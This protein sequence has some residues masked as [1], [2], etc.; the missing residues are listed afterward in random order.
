MGSE[1]IYSLG[2]VP[3]PVTGHRLLFLQERNQG[4][5]SMISGVLHIFS[6]KNNS[7]L[8]FEVDI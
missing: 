3:F 5:V 2:S 8:A 1:V 6:T 4:S 7:V